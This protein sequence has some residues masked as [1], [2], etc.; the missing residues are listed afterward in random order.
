MQSSSSYQRPAVSY[1][2][3]PALPF[4]HVEPPESEQGS[5]DEELEE[6]EQARFEWQHMLSNVLQGDV[7]KSE[8]T[9]IS[10]ASLSTT[11][12]ANNFEF[13]TG[14]N[15][16]KRQRAYAIWLLVRAKVRGRSPEEE[17]RYIEEAR[18]QVDEVLDEVVKFRVV[19][20][21]PQGGIAIEDTVRQR[22]AMDQVAGLLKRVDWCESLY[23][24]TK[25]LALEKERVSETQ[26]VTRLEALRSWQQITRRIEVTIGILKKWTGSD[27]EA[28][29]SQQSKDGIVPGA[30]IPALAFVEVI[31]REDSLQTT[32]QKRLLSDL[33]SLVHVAK[34]T[35]I[36]LSPSFFAMNLPGFTADLL[37]L[38]VFPS[39]LAQEAL[40]TRLESVANIHDPSVVLIDQLTGDLRKGLDTACDI[41]RQ[42]SLIAEPDPV[43]GWSL[44]ERVEE[45]EE[46][47]LSALRFFFKLLHWKLKSPSK[48]IYFKET[49][50]VESEWGFLSAV[51]EQIEGGDLLVGEHFRFV[52]P[53]TTVLM[54]CS[55]LTHRLLLRV[56]SYFET[57]LQVLETRDMTIQEMLRW[58]NQTLDN[59]RARHRKLLRFGKCVPSCPRAR[60]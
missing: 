4:D 60:R 7:L 6:E 30:P 43:S 44:P 11:S 52:L 12:L 3:T 45:Y 53:P 20:L 56:M 38:A 15:S 13:A 14:G 2:L 35:M 1:D 55:T 51:T 10:T 23:P 36:E 48:A 47:L 57:Q 37:A 19:D 41:K 50:I 42:Y 22:N 25:A 5:G 34:A 26:V 29:S 40:R 16:S 28:L 31:V 46:T 8:K 33:A 54:S 49:E 59:V 24:S 21:L 58:F 9:R 18:V 27:W 39:R 32:F 17:S